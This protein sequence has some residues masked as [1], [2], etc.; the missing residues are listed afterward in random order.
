MN[1]GIRGTLFVKADRIVERIEDY[2]EVFLNMQREKKQKI[3]EED[4][5]DFIK[6]VRLI[7]TTELN[8]KGVDTWAKKELGQSS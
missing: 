7:V 8:D 4:F 3:N 1:A 5:K 2:G 6:S